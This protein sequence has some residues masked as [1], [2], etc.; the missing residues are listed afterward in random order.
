[1]TKILF[2]LTYDKISQFSNWVYRPGKW[3]EIMNE[4]GAKL[5]M[6]DQL[7]QVGARL[8]ILNKSLADLDLDSFWVVSGLVWIVF[9]LTLFR[10]GFFRAAHGQGGGKKDP[11]P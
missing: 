6:I 9:H 7:F 2:H 1:M 5:T 8:G 3:K 4:N 10:M 11:P